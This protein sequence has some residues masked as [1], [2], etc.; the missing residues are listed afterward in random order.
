M[1]LFILL[2]Q[3][4]RNFKITCMTCILLIFLLDIFALETQNGLTYKWVWASVALT[5]HEKA[6]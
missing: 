2:M 4:T 1:F 6:C 5:T 3:K